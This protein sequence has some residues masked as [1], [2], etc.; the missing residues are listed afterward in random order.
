MVAIE[1]LLWRGVV[2]EKKNSDE[3]IIMVDEVIVK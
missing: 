1:R 2:I 3:M